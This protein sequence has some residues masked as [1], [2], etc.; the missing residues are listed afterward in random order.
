[1]LRLTACSTP[2]ARIHIPI[3]RIYI[4]M[5]G[6]G[7]P[8]TRR[9]ATPAKFRR[10]GPAQASDYLAACSGPWHAHTRIHVLFGRGGDRLRTPDTRMLYTCAPHIYIYVS[11]YIYIHIYVY[12]S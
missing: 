2:D 3:M 12:I 11:I 9:P 5:H 6:G 4:Y 8:A 10:M 7:G 1:M